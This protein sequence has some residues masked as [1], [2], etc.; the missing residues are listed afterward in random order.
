MRI[1]WWRLEQRKPPTPQDVKAAAQKVADMPDAADG[2]NNVPV[3]WGVVDVDIPGDLD[4]SQSKTK[5]VTIA[6]LKTQPDDTSVDRD[7]LTWH[8][9]HPGQSE[10]GLLHPYVFKTVDGDRVIVDGHNRLFAL[11]LLDQQDAQ[12][13]QLKEKD[14][15]E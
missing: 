14:L 1:N 13:F 11:L 6:N 7:K 4:W 3:P 8:V 9:H 2:N 12:V 5:T 10:K 15:N